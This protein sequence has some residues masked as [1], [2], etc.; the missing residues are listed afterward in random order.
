M[1]QKSFTAK[2]LFKNEQKKLFDLDK[3]FAHPKGNLITLVTTEIDSTDKSNKILFH[4]LDS[5]DTFYE[6]MDIKSPIQCLEYLDDFYE[7]TPGVMEMDPRIREK[8]YCFLLGCKN[9]DLFFVSFLANEPFKVESE[10]IYNFVKKSR[11]GN[12]ELSS[13]KKIKVFAPKEGSNK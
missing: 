5:K 2:Y 11:S 1:E 9:G 10:L 7:Y 3:L 4:C 8:F 13:I 12:A 6:P